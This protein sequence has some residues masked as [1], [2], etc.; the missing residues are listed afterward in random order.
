MRIAVESFFTEV[1]DNAHDLP[2][3]A[4]AKL[5][6][7][8]ER[9]LL[10]PVLPGKGFVDDEYAGSRSIVLFGESEFASTSRWNFRRIRDVT[11]CTEA[12]TGR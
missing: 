3:D 10:G 2:S 5:D 11:A 12:R 4:L 7:L 6:L 1:D 8:A 9:I